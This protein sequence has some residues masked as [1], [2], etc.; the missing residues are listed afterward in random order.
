MK[1]DILEQFA[2][3]LWADAW[4]DWNDDNDDHPMHANVSGE[5]IMDVMPPI[6]DDV[7]ELARVAFGKIA[8]LNGGCEDFLKACEAVFKRDGSNIEYLA[9]Y[10]IMES[11]GHGVAYEDAYPSHG[12]KVLGYLDV[13]CYYDEALDEEELPGFYVDMSI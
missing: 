10:L 12:L 9:H 8:D 3:T 13:I 1:E 4:A 7:S 11:M 2:K 6:P 5:E